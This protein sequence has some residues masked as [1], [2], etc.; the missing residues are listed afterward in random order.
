MKRLVL[1]LL[2][3]SCVYAQATS[4]RTIGVLGTGYVGLVLGACLAD[5]GHE[6]I[7][8]DIDKEKIKMLNRGDIPIYEPGLKE[9]VERSKKKG[10]ISFSD[11]PEALIR[12]CQVIFIAVG[13]ADNEEGQGRPFGDQ[14][15]FSNYR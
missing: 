15:G 7:C 3:F 9:I 14:S 2:L 10:M 12:K 13:T 8:G 4:T 6:V 5:F 11:D 1:Y